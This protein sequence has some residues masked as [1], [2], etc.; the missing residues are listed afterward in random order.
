MKRLIKKL[1][2]S[3]GLD[4]GRLDRAKHIDM[5]AIFATLR[6][7]EPHVSSGLGVIQVG[8]NDGVSNDPIFE[9]V[10]RFADKALLLEPQPDV[11]MT[12]A[13]NY[14]KFRGELEIDSRAVS[15][16]KKIILYQID[17]G[18]VSTIAG[19]NLSG[20][21]SSDKDHVERYA[22]RYLGRK[23][24][25]NFIKQFEVECVRL[26]E[27]IAR[28]FD[29]MEVFLQ[30][31][32]E[33]ADWD[34]LQTLGI[35]R[36]IAINFEMKHLKSSVIHKAFEWLRFEGYDLFPHAGDCLAIKTSGS[37]RKSS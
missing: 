37:A 21:T 14:G 6:V 32:C 26:D 9:A 34:V 12:L 18:S 2:S 29:K 17:I 5:A 13:E 4:I 28:H 20:V 11:R 35:E 23:Y 36:P 30:V 33:G 1:F 8:A 3:L 10:H 19:V 15:N 27:L 31:D 25:H 16:E 7:G 24:R 22:K